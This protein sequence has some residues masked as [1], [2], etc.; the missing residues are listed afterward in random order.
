MS[1]KA[2]IDLRS[3]FKQVRDQGNRMSCLSIAATD[4]HQFVRNSNLLSVEWLYFQSC[5]YPGNCP[6]KGTKISTTRNVLKTVGQP[7]EKDWPYE[8]NQP[9]NW[10]PPPSVGQLFRV[11][12]KSV[13]NVIKKFKMQLKNKIPVILVIYLSNGFSQQAFKTNFEL[14]ICADPNEKI[15][16]TRRHAILLVGLGKYEKKTVFLIRNSWG[17]GW[18]YGGYA[19][20]SQDYLSPRIVEGFVLKKLI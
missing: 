6:M 1:I 10:A 2:E 12:S 7:S 11:E 17:E 9:T 5:L 20:I 3:S 18:G 4:A 8:Q 14:P 16:Y 13:T 15:Y 19:W